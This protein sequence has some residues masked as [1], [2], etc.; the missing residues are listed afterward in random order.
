MPHYCSPRLSL[1]QLCLPLV[2]QQQVLLFM[3]MFCQWVCQS[4]SGILE[5]YSFWRWKCERMEAEPKWTS[6]HGLAKDVG[7]SK[8]QSEGKQRHFLTSICRPAYSSRA[9]QTCLVFVWGHKRKSVFLKNWQLLTICCIKTSAQTSEK[10][11]KKH[12]F[13]IQKL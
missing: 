9:L 13:P 12:Y 1:R 10:L 7:Q 4:T 2:K 5:T 8:G 11:D 6:N 3:F